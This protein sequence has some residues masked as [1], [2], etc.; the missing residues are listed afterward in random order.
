MIDINGIKTGYS[1]SGSGDPILF[2]HGAGF[3]A[4]GKSSFVRQ[5]NGLSDA[6]RVITVDQLHFGRTDYPEDGQYIDRLGRVDHII[7]FIELMGLRNLTLAGHS[8]GSFVA[9]R[10]AIVRPDLV[11][12]LILMTSS[13]VSPAF[14]DDRDR[15]WVQACLEYYDVSSPM[16]TEDQYIEKRR[17]NSLA[18]APDLEAVQREAY[19]R[20]APTPQYKMFQNIPSH[21]RDPNVYVCLQQKYILPYLEQIKCETKIIWSRNDA[22]VPV[23]RGYKLATLIG[24]AE[25]HLLNNA[26]HSIQIDRSDAVNNI[27]RN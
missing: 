19:R 20:A 12:K 17:K 26:K 14:N 15:A 25:F 6:F 11:K 27:I 22:T 4:E 13:A 1:E 7:R 21:E 5:L 23:H 3:G 9:A 18:Y 10:I 16:P 24:H 2:L 8:E